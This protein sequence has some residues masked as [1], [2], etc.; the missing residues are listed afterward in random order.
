[1]LQLTISK[2]ALDFLHNLRPLQIDLVGQRLLP[3]Y[4]IK[5][6]IEA[7]TVEEQKIIVEIQRE[8]ADD[9]NNA[10][11]FISNRLQHIEI[12]FKCEFSI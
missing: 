11:N 9:S 2:H 5:A 10:Q 8:R 4:A 7:I 1:M 12:A 6:H 3:T